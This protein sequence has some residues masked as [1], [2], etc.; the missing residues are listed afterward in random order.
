MSGILGQ[1][2]GGLMQGQAGQG[3]GDS[4]LGGMLGQLLGG[5]EQSVSGLQGLTEQLRQAGLGPQVDSW[6]GHGPNAPVDPNALAS[7]LGHDQVNGLARSSGLA[8]GG[9]AA[10]LAA[11]LPTVI[12]ALTPQGRLPR[13]AQEV[14]PTDG[15]SALLGG[16][17]QAG[18]GG[19]DAL[20]GSLGGG[21]AAGQGSGGHGGSASGEGLTDGAAYGK[22]APGS[23]GGRKG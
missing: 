21:A 18:G 17:G 13:N 2:L 12:N 23:D 8:G 22:R 4:G 19:L 5:G 14:P 7:A 16:Q 10:V 9:M 20:L 15:L 1:M 6:I 3:G 11:L